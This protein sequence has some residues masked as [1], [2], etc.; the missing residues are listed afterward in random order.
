MMT[1]RTNDFYTAVLLKLN[2]IP[3]KSIEKINNK[4]VDFVF[5]ESPEVCEQI[6]NDYWDRSPM[7]IPLRD[8]IDEIKMLKSV[9]YEE[10]RKT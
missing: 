7:T 6:K 3:I 4:F 1:Y 2:N 9:I 10:L 8:V 5:A